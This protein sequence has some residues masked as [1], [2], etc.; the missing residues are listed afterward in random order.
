MTGLLNLLHRY[1]PDDNLTVILLNNG[2]TAMTGGQPNASSSSYGDGSD[3]NVD[4]PKLIATMGFDRV[5]VVDQFDYKEAK[6]VIE[7][8]IRFEGLSIVMT[9]R[10]CALKFKIKE[11]NFYVDPSVCIACRTC[12]KTNCPPIHMKDYKGFDKQKSS[13][14]P[15]MCVGCS[16]CSQVCPVGAIKRRV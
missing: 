5:R 4:L 16:V 11:P 15:S 10:P 1:D 13:I 7:E 14:D 6:K 8:E 2:T 3:M 12:V 9:T